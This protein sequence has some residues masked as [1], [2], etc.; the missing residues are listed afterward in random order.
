MFDKIPTIISSV[1]TVIQGAGLVGFT[2][3]TD[4]LI[5]FASTDYPVTGIY[6]VQDKQK[7]G[8][9]SSGIHER[10]LSL[11]IAIYML[12]TGLSISSVITPNADLIAKALLNSNNLNGVVRYMEDFTLS[13]DVVK[14]DE[15]Y[16]EGHLDFLLTYVARVR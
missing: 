14:Q 9:A 13:F 1:N 11:R 4:E 2:Y 10:V 7:D 8:L 15:N 5:D 6:V 3:R 12:A 16:V